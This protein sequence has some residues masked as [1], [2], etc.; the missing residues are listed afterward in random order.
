MMLIDYR[1]RDTAI[2]DI[3]QSRNIPF[4]FNNL[5]VG[6][7][8][9][10]TNVIERKEIKDFF[11]SI[12][13][14]H[15]YDQLEDIVFNLS[16]GFPRAFL[17]LHGSI[18][19]I[20]WEYAGGFTVPLFFTKIGEII[21][22]YPNVNF[23]WLDCETSF[24]N[25][26]SGMYFKSFQEKREIQ[27]LKKRDK[28]FDVDTLCATRCFDPKTAKRILK[29]YTLREIFNLDERKLTSIEGYGKVRA[30][31]FIAMR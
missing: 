21:S 15:M 5:P 14:N 12:Q 25:F 3:L 26:L 10:N 11:S 27:S 9:W 22:S 30:Q 1:E 4:E 13:N 16:N 17:V 28:R 6:D 8:I 24:A 2:L 20:N 29:K 23:V 19:D 7:Y 31:K 18:I